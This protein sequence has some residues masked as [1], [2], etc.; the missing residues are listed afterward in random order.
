MKLRRG[1]W[2][3]GR[4]SGT[5]STPSRIKRQRPAVSSSRNTAAVSPPGRVWSS[6]PERLSSSWARVQ[7]PLPERPSSRPAHSRSRHSRGNRARRASGSVS[8]NPSGAGMGWSGSVPPAANKASQRQ[9]VV[10]PEP[11]APGT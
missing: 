8:R 1:R 11:G 3:P 4:V 7:W 6:Q 5:S 2:P 9:K 10:L